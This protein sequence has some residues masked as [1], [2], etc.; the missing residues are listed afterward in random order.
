MFTLFVPILRPTK[1]IF[2]IHFLPFVIYF[3]LFPQLYKSELENEFSQFMDWL[4]IFP[5]Y[6]GK[7][8]LD[9]EEEDESTRYMG[10]FKVRYVFWQALMSYING[11][12]AYA[13][14]K[15]RIKG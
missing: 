9:D 2:R 15:S 7:S 11:V 14:R 1:T 3:F 10:K 5:V 8:S 12:T 4:H 6:K 13:L